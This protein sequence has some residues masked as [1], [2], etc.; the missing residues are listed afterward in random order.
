MASSYRI[1]ARVVML[2]PAN[3]IMKKKYD[4]K[5][6][7]Y[8]KALAYLGLAPC[9]LGKFHVRI[10]YRNIYVCT[11]FVRSKVLKIFSYYK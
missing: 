6:N 5:D 10:Y 8:S 1:L 2:W 7:I 4:L 3:T 11:L 9:W